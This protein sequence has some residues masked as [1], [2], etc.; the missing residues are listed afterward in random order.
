MRNILFLLVLIMILTCT[1][2]NNKQVVN[3]E[4]IDTAGYTAG[5]GDESEESADNKEVSETLK[6]EHPD[7]CNQLVQRNNSK[8]WDVVNYKFA[9][10][11]VNEAA[12]KYWPSSYGLADENKVIFIPC[13]YYRQIEIINDNRFCAAK[14]DKYYLLNEK[15][16]V[17]YTADFM[18][19]N[20][21]SGYGVAKF[22]N[23][24]SNEKKCYLINL[25]GKILDDKWDNI[26]LRG[27]NEGFYDTKGKMLFELDN[28]GK[29]I[30]EVDTSPKI[31]DSTN[32]KIDI[33]YQENPLDLYGFYGAIDKKGNVII[34][35]KNNKYN[36]GIKVIGDNCILASYGYGTFDSSGTDIYDFNGNLI[37]KEYESLL[38]YNENGVYTQYGIAGN[39]IDENK[40]VF[41]YYLINQK[42]EVICELSY[43]SVNF[44]D[45]DTL[46]VQDSENSSKHYIK[47][48]ELL[49]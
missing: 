2:C 7:L 23:G 43:Y 17:L 41:R 22:N 42:A 47:L 29:V 39:L 3:E 21:T 49:N 48:N 25:D 4:S 34:P 11:A 14:S 32:D 18:F 40:I 8:Y 36:R 35:I 20:Y 12:R 26:E 45:K 6:K 9:E 30:K 1:S 37:N 28:N 19:F 33:I 27:Q 44:K 5:R 46:C 16:E 10:A 24:S 15:C 13:E 31:F 38:F